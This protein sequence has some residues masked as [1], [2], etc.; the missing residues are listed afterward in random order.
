M[1]NQENQGQG[2]WAKNKLFI[3]IGGIVLLFLLI[4]IPMSISYS[5]YANRTEVAAKEKTK[6]CTVDY[7]AMWKIIQQQAGVT[8]EYKSAF[9][10]IYSDL[11]DGR[12]STNDGKGALMSWIQEDNPTFDSKLF[13]KLMNTIESQRTD[14]ATRQKELIAIENDYNQERVTFPGSWFIGD[15]PE[16]EVTLIT[17]AKTKQVY[18]TG[19]DNDIELF[20]K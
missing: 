14:F 15:R 12:Y 7:D 2:F 20:N 16:M 6:A 5:N 3:I 13:D 8:S 10:E 1:E 18:E 11:I 19:E 9:K 17:S 4:Y